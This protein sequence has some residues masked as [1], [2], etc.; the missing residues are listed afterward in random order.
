MRWQL[1]LIL[2]Y[3]ITTHKSQ[4]MTAHNGIVYEPSKQ[5]PFARGL[6]YVAISRATDLEKVALLL[7]IRP[8]HF[9]NKTF[10]AENIKITEFYGN[11]NKKFN[12]DEE[13]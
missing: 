6:P 11:L 7:P 1:P 8:D 12:S 13:I 5:K 9:M 2:V 3:S 4:S 10:I